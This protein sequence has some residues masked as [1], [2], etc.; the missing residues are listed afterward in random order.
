MRPDSRDVD[1]PLSDRKISDRAVLLPLVGLLLLTP[2][3]AGIFQLDIRVFGIPFTGFY[4]FGVWAA[5]IVG[6]AVLSRRIRQGADW[7][8]EEEIR[9]R[10]PV[11]DID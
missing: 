11:D 1:R 10:D 7:G 2:P 3:L 5:L 9:N 4:L 8:A 6:A